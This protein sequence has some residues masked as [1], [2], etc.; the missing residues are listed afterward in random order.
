MAGIRRDVASLGN[1]WSVPMLW[2]A[3]AVRAMMAKPISDPTSWTALA[4]IH[5]CDLAGWQTDGL[6][7]AGPIPSIKPEWNQCEHGKWYFLPWHRGYLASFEAIVA[8]TIAGLGGPVWTLPYWNYLDATALN[9]RSLPAVFTNPTLPD[10]SA[11]P[12]A[13]WPRQFTVLAPHPSQGINN[14]ISL[15]STGLPKF[16]SAPGATGF[17]GAPAAPGG[18]E[19]NPHNLVHVM[20]GGLTGTTG[21]MSDPDYAG[22]DPIFWLHHCNIDRLWAAWLTNSANT[23]E[24]GAVWRAGPTVPKYRLP[25]VSGALNSF[26]PADTLPG[27]RLAPTYDDLIKGTGQ[28]AAAVPAA[29][30]IA[31][32]ASLSA[33]PPTPTTLVGATVTNVVVQPG[34]S[35]TTDLPL[36]T[37]GMPAGVEEHRLFLN[38]ENITGSKPSGML[39]VHIGVKPSATANLHGLDEYVE[40]LA[41]FGLKKA[42][43]PD[44]PHGG[45][46]MNFTIDITDAVALL[47]R[48]AA[49]DP[50][51]LEV[52]ITQPGSGEGAAPITVGRVS[53]YS[54]P[55]D[56]V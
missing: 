48:S 22:L 38:I 6:I 31:M 43:D 40:G 5:G 30:E 20:I 29:L 53:V 3:K 33:Q 26:K 21:Y 15:S 8:T 13:R 23:Q 25:D 24:N 36:D 14:D 4:A 39:D 35:V 54:Q 18:L 42:S 9:A 32:P 11:N 27:Q 51:D 52:K 56:P 10:G 1:G 37:A 55:V 44:G 17:G 7:P 49:V 2:Y 28:S 34:A 46:G 50:A 47:T 19:S 45:N 16:T 41:L 12:L